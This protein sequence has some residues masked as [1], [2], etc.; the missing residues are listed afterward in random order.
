MKTQPKL[1]RL[2]TPPPLTQG[3]VIHGTDLK[4]VTQSA[5]SIHMK[6][7][8]PTSAPRTSPHKQQM[9]TLHP[10]RPLVAYLLIPSEERDKRTVS[11]SVIVQ[12]IKSK[13]IVASISLPEIACS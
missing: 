10:S 1:L 13:A 6:K 2:L 7:S 4:S 12:D 3:D 5:V 11:K 9:T 8:S